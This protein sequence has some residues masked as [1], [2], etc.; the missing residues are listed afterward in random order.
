MWVH[1]Q[2]FEVIYGL[3]NQTKFEHQNTMIEATDEMVWIQNQSS[4]KLFDGSCKVSAKGL[5]CSL[6]EIVVWSFA[7]SE[8]CT[9]DWHDSEP[10]TNWIKSILGLHCLSAYVVALMLILFTSPV[11]ELVAHYTIVI[12]TLSVQAYFDICKVFCVCCTCNR[13]LASG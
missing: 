12:I 1:C 10:D 11:L 2:L 5:L 13:S 9:R 3:L 8:R 6:Q 7:L 4:F